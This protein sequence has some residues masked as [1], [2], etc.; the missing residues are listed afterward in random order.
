MQ[1][2]ATMTEDQK[3]HV[4]LEAERALLAAMAVKPKAYFDVRGIISSDVFYSTEHAQMCNAIEAAMEENAEMPSVEGWSPAMEHLEVARK[5]VDLWQKRQLAALPTIIRDDL[6]DSKTKSETIIEHMTKQINLANA[7]LKDF[8]TDR[9]LSVATLFPQI[10]ADLEK[11]RGGGSGVLTG[12]PVLDEMLGG[13]QPALHIIAGRPGLGKTTFMLQVA[14]YVVENGTPV[15]FVSFDEVLWRL[16]LKIFCQKGGLVMK[17]YADGRYTDDDYEE[18]QEVYKEYKDQLALLHFV[19]GTA[20]LDVPQ[21]ES[22]CRQTMNRTKSKQALVIVDY[23]Q[24]WASN[25]DDKINFEHIVS[26]LVG[27]LRD[28]AFRLESP[29]VV[30]SS[31]TREGYEEPSLKDLKESGELEFSADTALM[32]REN[33]HGTERMR[34]ID[35]KLTPRALRLA[36]AKNRYGDMGEI[37]YQFNLQKGIIIEKA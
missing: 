24:R 37:N 33:V 3:Q 22:M 25:V 16:T 1:E 29:V 2:H 7:L 26:G 34:R 23:L 20:T 10:V 11:R 15:V 35:T 32:L 9:S 17:K 8:R 36:I 30:V 5:L 13:L 14:T 4:D 12:F 28:M 31:L 6:M 18:L 21:L 27:Q 19:E